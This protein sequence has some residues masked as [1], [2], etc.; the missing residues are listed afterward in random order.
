MIKNVMNKKRAKRRYTDLV[1]IDF[2]TTG[3]K[4]VRL[5]QTGDGIA[6]MG[7]DLMPAVDFHSAPTR[8]DLPRNMISYY[9]ALCYS[10]PEAVIRMLNTPVP[11]GVETLYDSKIRELLNVTEEY[12]PSARLIKLGK[13]RQDS[14]FLAAAIPQD[15]VSFMLNMFP[16][17]PPAPASLEVSGL[18]VISAF[19]HSRGEEC[20]EEAVCLI[21]A[22]ETTSHFAFL[23]K[24]TVL[25]VGKLDFGSLKLRKKLAAD[26]G[27]D[28]DLANSILN[29]RSINIS[30]S[31]A[32]VLEPFSKQVSISKDF[33]ERH[34][35]CRVSKV[36][37]SGGLS[38]LPSWSNEIG[39]MLHAEVIR[40]SPLE[41][42]QYEAD[43]LPPEIEGQSTRFAAAIG[44]ALGGF[45][46]Q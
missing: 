42:I 22:G 46:D 28:D 39:Q 6:L 16:A 15:D 18:S 20:S 37:V 24:G 31:L 41:K 8:L 7:I 11:D 4:V 33:I 38:M 44:A 26:L 25:L 19:L 12:R 14:S 9:G 13:G 36:Y 21:E 1:G 43:I 2:A 45:A 40:W 32:S 10:C 30:A 23:N 3:T 27:V 5:K 35:G 17:G 34:Q 29:D